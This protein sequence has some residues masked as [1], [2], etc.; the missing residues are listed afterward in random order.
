MWRI[1]RGINSAKKSHLPE[2]PN[3]MAIF[4]VLELPMQAHAEQ[5]VAAAGILVEEMRRHPAVSVAFIH[6]CQNVAEIAYLH[7]QQ[8]LDEE[9]AL[10]AIPDLSAPTPAAAW[11]GFRKVGKGTNG[12]SAENSETRPGK[13]TAKVSNIGNEAT[14]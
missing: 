13:K 10:D 4:G 6:Y 8:P 3:D 7:F 2:R 11:K 9:P 5:R 12:K 14:D 1:V